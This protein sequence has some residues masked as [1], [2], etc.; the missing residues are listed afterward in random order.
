MLK[1]PAVIGSVLALAL[2]A[3]PAAFAAKRN[4][5]TELQANKV[6]RELIQTNANAN[7]FTG[8]GSFQ[9][10]GSGFISIPSTATGFFVATFSAESNCSG[11]APGDWC[12]VVITCDGVALQPDT[13]IGFAFDSVGPTSSTVNWHSLSMTRRSNVVTGGT[14]SCE[15]RTAQTAA[16]TS[17]RLDEWTFEVQFWKQ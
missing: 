10:T 11:G 3:A 12:T 8:T 14:H 5:D 7:V 15:V 16:A 2:I 1:K 4:H 17:L 9:V 6:I 13:G